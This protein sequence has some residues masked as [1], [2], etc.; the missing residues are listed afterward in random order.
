MNVGMV[1]DAEKKIM[2]VLKLRMCR[3]RIC[4][5]G[6]TLIGAANEG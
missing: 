3:L 4:V 1:Y 2:M 6:L 5:G